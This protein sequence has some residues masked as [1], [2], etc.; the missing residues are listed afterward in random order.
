MPLHVR[1]LV[2]MVLGFV[3]G[4]IAVNFDA[5][6]LIV[7]WVKPFGTIF[8]NLLKMIAAPLIIVSL[9]KGISDMRDL[10]RLSALSGR[11]FALIVFTTMASVALGLVLV[12]VIRPGEAIDEATRSKLLAASADAAAGGIAV[13][14][15]AKKQGPLQPII[16]LVPDNI[17]AAAANNAAMLQVI[18]FVMLFG[19][20]L[21]MTPAEKSTPVKA[22]FDGLNDVVMR[23]IELVMHTAPIGVFALL[24]ALV[25]ETP[26]WDVFEA[27]L[28]YSLCVFLG[29]VILTFVFYPALVWTFAGVG[30]SHFFRCMAPAQL[31]A[32]STSSSAATLPVTMECVRDRLGVDE[33]VASFV[34]PIGATINK[35]G[36]SLFMAVAA[37]FIAQ[38]LGIELTM[39]D[40]LTILFMATLASIG[41]A[42]VPSAGIVMLVIVLG[43]VN[44]PEQGIALILTVD[45][46]LDM[47]RTVPN[48]TDDA[49]VAVLVA[50]STGRM[51]SPNTTSGE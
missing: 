11:T 33:E 8:I 3:A 22:F 17:F 28:W 5:G 39:G 20:A 2:S 6:W 31:L 38:T 41:T 13:A 37:V 25:A 42:S 44:V 43:S 1:I 26:S 40:Q 10:G 34:L 49:A 32:F 23:V 29:Q 30:Y 16:D 12:N 48:I 35:N 19:V 36:T 50:K 18:V 51:A 9:V 14:E 24:A 27:L 7:D 45:R 46:V 47:C 4:L 15:Q 21:V